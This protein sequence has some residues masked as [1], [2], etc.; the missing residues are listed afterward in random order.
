MFINTTTRSSLLH[1]L[2]LSSH[3]LISAA[4][5]LGGRRLSFLLLSYLPLFLLSA[6]SV[7]LRLLFSPVSFLSFLLPLSLIGLAQ[8]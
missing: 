3:N 7:P 8:T 5:P 6:S 1:F 2:S 4:A